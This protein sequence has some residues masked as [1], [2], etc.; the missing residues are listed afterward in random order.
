MAEENVEGQHDTTRLQKEMEVRRQ[1]MVRSVEDSREKLKS[2]LG[3]QQAGQEDEG[4]S[5]KP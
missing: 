1:E 3:P 2:L 4:K 5:D